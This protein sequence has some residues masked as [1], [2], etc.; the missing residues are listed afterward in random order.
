MKAFRFIIILVMLGACRKDIPNQ[1]STQPPTSFG[2]VFED[3]WNDMSVNYVYWDLDTTDWDAMYVRYQPL[4]ARLTWGDSADLERSVGYFR[5]MTDGLIDHHYYMTFLPSILTDSIVDPAIDQLRGQPG[6]RPPV[7]YVNLD[8]RRLDPG[9]VIGTEGS[10]VALAGTIGDSILFF[11]CNQFALS[12]A[13]QSGDDNRVRNV[14]TYFFDHLSNPGG[15][16]A[17]LLDFRDNPGG[18]VS[19]LDFLGGQFIQQPLHFGYTRYKSGNGRLSYTPWIDTYV[20]PQVGASVPPLPLI[21]LADRYSASLAEIL[22]MALRVLPGCRIVGEPTFG[23]TGPYTDNVLYDDG[24]FSIPG[25]LS[26]LTSSTE[27]E[28]LD[29]KRY[30]GKGF[31]P[32]YPVAFEAGALASGDDPQMDKALSLVE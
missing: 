22:T 7:S 17:I 26:V 19:D 11:T 28:Y 12:A 20:H 4:F 9:Y 25:Y 27:F 24:P 21:I 5:A 31:P 23:A 3:F 32:D 29:G 14:L 30:E 10:L 13:W 2:Q 1:I 15:L 16:K 18:D 8:Q 6:F